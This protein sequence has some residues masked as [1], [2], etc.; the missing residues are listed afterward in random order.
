MLSP[1][2]GNFRNTSSSRGGTLGGLPGHG[3]EGIIRGGRALADIA[4]ETGDDLG[5]AVI[6]NTEQVLNESLNLIPVLSVSVDLL[7]MSDHVH[8][9]N[10][11]VVQDLLLV[12]KLSEKQRDI[13]DGASII[14]AI[15]SL[16]D[17][18]ISLLLAEKHVSRSVALCHGTREQRRR[19]DRES[20]RIGG[21]KE[22]GEG[23]DAEHGGFV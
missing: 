2:L 12:L 4:G 18:V 9:I 5:V 13:V 3:V 16:A 14:D 23:C 22:R 21:E 11:T 7:K 19:S 20:T 10:E 17:D 6:E 15:F 8:D 1:S